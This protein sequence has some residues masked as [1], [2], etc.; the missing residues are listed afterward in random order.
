MI[1]VTVAYIYDE[2]PNTYD[3]IPD[4]SSNIYDHNIYDPSHSCLHL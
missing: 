4:I 3:L 1:L 2:I